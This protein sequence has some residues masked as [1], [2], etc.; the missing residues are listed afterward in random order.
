MSIIILGLGPGDANL[1]TREA[2]SALEGAAEIWLRTRVHP[3]VKQLPRHLKLHSFY[4][5]YRKHKDF[6]DVYAAIVNRVLREAKRGDVIYAVPG[7]P[8]IAESTVQQL[9]ARARELNIET[10]IVGGVSFIEPVIERLNAASVALDPIHGLQICDALELAAQHHP[11]LNP[12]KGA[13]IAQVYSRAVA[14]NLKLTLMNQYAPQHVVWAIGATCRSVALAEL[15]HTDAFDH[16]TTVYVPAT[17]HISSFEGLQETMAHLRAPEG[18]PWDREQTHASLRNTLLEE[19]H[20][21]L[22]AIDTDDMDALREELGDLLFN[23]LFQAQMA[24]EAERFRMT[25]VI[26]TIDAKLKRRHP[27]VFAQLD[28]SDVGEVLRNWDA[29]KAQEKKDK[30]AKKISALDGIAPSLPA[31]AKAQKMSQRAARAGFKWDNRAQRIAKVREELN[32]VLSARGKRHRAEEIGDL[33]FTLCTLADADGIDAESALREACDKFSA[34]YQQMERLARERQL[35]MK[36]MRAG[37][38]VAL[39]NEAK[40]QLM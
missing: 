36:Q 8:L 9:M 34:R 27:H 37:A 20:E 12:D 39:W 26:A 23:V 4:A 18:C 30:G 19:A 11:P 10:R 7:H 38:L 6:A 24:T 28:V 1:L 13:L 21:V 14:S 16:L 31:L 29:I 3:T 17:T 33:L 25:D 32:E 5:L 35:D 22:H 40:R 15:D 2:W